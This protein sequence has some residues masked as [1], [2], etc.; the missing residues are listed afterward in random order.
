MLNNKIKVQRAERG[1][2]QIELANLVGVTRQTIAFIE[3]GEF[4][5]SVTL[6]LKLADALQVPITTLFWLS[7]E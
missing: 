5:P 3:K 1:Y 7:E 6:A 4:A 2:T